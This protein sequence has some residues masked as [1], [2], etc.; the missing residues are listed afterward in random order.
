MRVVA[1]RR[2]DAP[3][4]LVPDGSYETRAGDHLVLIGERATLEALA[5]RAAAPPS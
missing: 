3:I 1:L 5:R 2:D 4:E